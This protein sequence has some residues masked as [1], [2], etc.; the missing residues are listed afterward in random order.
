MAAEV[1]VA[2][3]NVALA[4]YAHPD[5]ADV[6]CGGALAAWSARGCVVHLLVCASGDKGSSDPL[7][8]PGDLVALRSREVDAASRALGI[9]EVHRLDRADG[10]LENEVGLRGDIVEVVRRVRPDTVVCPDPTAV[11]FGEHYFNH[12]D[13]R[14]TGWATLDA[15]APAA[16]SPL[17][18]PDRGAAHQVESVLLSGTLDPNVFVDISASLDAKADAILCHASQLDGSGEWFRSV[19]RERAEEAGR[20]A[21]VPYAEGFRRLRLTS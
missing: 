11:F 12:H 9:V 20:A 8:D 14:A 3:P 21:G 2:V 7:V 15:V 6:S 19:V 10:S 13:H 18:H 16:S 1:I 4:V 5:D 17:Y